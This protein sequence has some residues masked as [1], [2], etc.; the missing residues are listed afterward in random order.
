MG[1]QLLK[2]YEKAYALGGMKARMRLA[3]LTKIPTQKAE[4]EPD[5]PGNL[6]KFAAAMNELSKE[7]K[8]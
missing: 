1:Q 4:S 7:F 3:V 6:A 8:K 2:E 5:S